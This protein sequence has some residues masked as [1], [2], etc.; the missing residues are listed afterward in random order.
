VF[1]GNDIVDL[2]LPETKD[3]AENKSFM[4]RVFDSHEL[5]CINSAAKP[6]RVLWSIWAA[7]ETAFKIAL[8]LKKEVIFSP[9]KFSVQCDAF[10]AQ[11]Q[12]LSGLS[13]FVNFENHFFPVRWDYKQG[14]VHCLGLGIS[15]NEKRVKESLA[16]LHKA[17][18]IG[19][20]RSSQRPYS[21]RDSL[22]L[23]SIGN[24]INSAVNDESH[25]VRDLAKR[26][27]SQIYDGDF[28]IV[29]SL[30][31][32]GSGTPVIF[33]RGHPVDGLDLSLSHHGKFVAAAV[34]MSSPSFVR[35][36]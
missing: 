16:P 27:I 29:K 6:N 17:I 36:G 9:K 11:G 35:R 13:G 26:L 3:K 33:S 12:P 18:H 5:A 22:I 14:Y 2:T 30:S 21:K 19:D 10:N 4:S 20:T 8:K 1:V 28:E 24:T 32:H 15:A 34:T 25:D 31:K 23:F 7:K